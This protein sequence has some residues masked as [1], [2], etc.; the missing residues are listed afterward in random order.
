MPDVPLGNDPYTWECWLCVT[1]DGCFA[2][3][4]KGERGKANGLHFQADMT[5]NHCK[6]RASL[7]PASSR[8]RTYQGGGSG[9]AGDEW[10]PTP[11]NSI[12]K[13]PSK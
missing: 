6:C 10:A 9:D 3:Y 11:P 7:L 12:S 13:P 8:V 2:G 4:G 5:I 1:G